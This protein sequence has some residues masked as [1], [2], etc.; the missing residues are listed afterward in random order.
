MNV[1]YYAFSD[2]T[3]SF[4][5][6]WYGHQWFKIY[7]SANISNG[8]DISTQKTTGIAAQALQKMGVTLTKQSALA[9]FLAGEL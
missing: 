6:C 4:K 7:G 8:H 3:L 9:R 2:V 5:L 1:P